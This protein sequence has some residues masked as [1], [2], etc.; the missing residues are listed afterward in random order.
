MQTSNE[1]IA[2]PVVTVVQALIMY[3][4]FKHVKPLD[5]SF[6]WLSLIAW[7]VGHLWA[8]YAFLPRL[9]KIVAA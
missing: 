5:G 7:T 4:Q 8:L 9:C 3:S 1:C 6:Q 2:A